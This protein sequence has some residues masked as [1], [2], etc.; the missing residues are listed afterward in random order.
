MT[1][2]EAENEAENEAEIPGHTQV[3]VIAEEGSENQADPLQEIASVLKHQKLEK[4]ETGAAKVVAM[5]TSPD[6]WSVTAAKLPKTLRCL[7]AP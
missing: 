5:S 4:T 6:A 2:T 7:L 1:E 3:A